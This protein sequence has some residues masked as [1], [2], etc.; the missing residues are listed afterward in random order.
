M[1]QF[2]KESVIDAPRERVFAFH[3]RPDIFALLQPPWEETRIIKPPR[4][5]KVGTVVVLKT[6]LGPLWVTIEAEHVAYVENERFDDIMRR[7]PFAYWHH[8][9]LF[10]ARG[11]QCLLRDEID[12]ALPLGRLG[13]LLGAAFVRRK[14]DNLF[15]FRHA[16]TAREV[17][18][19]INAADRATSPDRFP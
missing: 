4:S 6:K 14:L 5:L 18:S 12:Y 16:L 3:A 11:E 13:N 19:G 7:G 9:H 1:Q 10:I 17:A 8:K 15:A 2:V